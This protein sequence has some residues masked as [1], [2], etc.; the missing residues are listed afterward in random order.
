M[1]CNVTISFLSAALLAVG[2][3]VPGSQGSAGT[4]SLIPAS[5]ATLEMSAGGKP[6][7]SW[8]GGAL[9]VVDSPGSTV[10]PSI[11]LFDRQGKRMSA[12][13]LSI[14]DALYTT[15]RDYRRGEDGTI[16]ICGGVVDSTGRAGSYVAWTSNHGQDI[17]VVRTSP[18][19][20]VQVTIAADGTIWTA[21]IE[22]KPRSEAETAV[23]RRFDRSGKTIGAYVRQSEI[24][25]RSAIMSLNVFGALEDRIVWYSN[26][27]GELV[28][29]YPDGTVN[30]IRDLFLPN[31]EGQGGFAITRDGEVFVNSRGNFSASISRLDRDRREWTPVVHQAWSGQPPFPMN[32]F[33]Y[34]A[35]GDELVGFEHSRHLKFLRI[36]RE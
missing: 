14:P 22:E 12:F 20:P 10:P 35:D 18:Y 34:G 29:V 27:A 19:I 1:Q 25:E 23:F 16:A 15:V 5:E 11:S 33:L 28:E 6:M 21:G 3:T 2:T 26:R 9:V 8:G 13:V 31:G 36:R 30:R 4:I 24:R 7:P 32:I 17:Q